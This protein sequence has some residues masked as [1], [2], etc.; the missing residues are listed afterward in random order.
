MRRFSLLFLYALAAPAWAVDLSLS[1]GDPIAQL[2]VELTPGSTVTLADG[3]YDL[4]QQLDWGGMGTESEPI[5]FQAASGARPVLRFES[6]GS[7]LRVAGAAWVEIRGLTI[8]NTDTRYA[9]ARQTGIVIADSSNV[10]LEDVEVR[11]I[12][13][14]GVHLAGNNAGLVLRRVHVHDTRD[15]S[16]MYVGCGN[17]SCWTEASVIENCWLHDLKGPGSRGI[18]VEH[19]GQGIEIVDNVVHD[20]EHGGIRVGSTEFG[21]PNVVERNAV[22]RTGQGG[23]QVYGAA[24]VRNNLVFDV[25][26]VGIYS[27]DNDRG[28]FG[29]VIVSHNTVANTTS[30]GIQIDGWAGHAGLV[31]ANN[32]VANPVGRA[33]EAGE[34][35]LDGAVHVAGNVL[36]GLVEAPLLDATLGDFQAGG[37]WADFVDFEAGDLYP[38]WDASFLAVG[39]PSAEAWVPADDFNGAPR[40]GTAPDA[41][42]YELSTRDNPGW[43]PTEGFKEPGYREAGGETVGGCGC[44][45]TGGSRSGAAA[46]PLL[47]ALA[48]L[49]RRSRRA[50]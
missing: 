31:L 15:G 23:L 38:T 50:T 24:I 2:A 20:V 45:S 41:G 30:W 28:A 25:Q 17:A 33:F 9:E 19:G 13:G 7:G 12:G 34:L 43:V 27:D 6:G 35:D 46:W 5:R 49:R 10:T 21:D 44:A 29:D 1:P 36:S 32:V 37:G 40:D 16:G 42:A 48:G 26:G 8:E 47:F 11:H 4:T 18:L 39:D 3:V 22:W 14:T